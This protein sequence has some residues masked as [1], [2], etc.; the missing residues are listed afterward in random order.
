MAFLPPSPGSQPID[1][2]PLLHHVA[3]GDREAFEQLYDRTSRYVF[4]VAV[5]VLDDRELAA[6]VAQEVYTQVWAE[7]ED[8]DPSRGSALTWIAMITRSRALDRSRSKTSY[9]EALE[10]LEEDPRSPPTGKAAQDPE[11]AVVMRERRALLREA[12]AE[13]PDEQRITLELSFFRGMSQREMARQTDTPLGTVKS[14]MR[15][16]MSKLEDRLAPVLGGG[17]Q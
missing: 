4:G 6:E 8:F 5:K 12:L 1:L 11:E 9:G 7:A 17:P 14:R 3:D 15:S 13:L 2:A 10:K 16:A